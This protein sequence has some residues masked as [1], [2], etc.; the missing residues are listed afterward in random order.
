M[1][2]G[3]EK[4]AMGSKQKFQGGAASPTVTGT[5]RPSPSNALAQ[6]VALLNRGRFADAESALPPHALSASNP[7]V[8]HLRGVIVREQGHHD[9]A[10]A[11]IEAA[12]RLNGRNLAYR[13]DL[14]HAFLMAERFSD[15]IACY[16]RVLRDEP[17]AHPARFGIGMARLGLNDFEAAA[18][19]LQAFVSAVPDHVDGHANLGTALSELGRH[20]E[21]ES[22]LSL[23]LAKRPNHPNLRV[24]Y[25]MALRRRG[26]AAAAA[27][28]L[29][30]AAASAPDLFEAH[31]QL[32]L[33]FVDLVRFDQAM[34]AFRRAAA[35]RPEDRA[36]LNE[37]GKALSRTQHY[38]EAAETFFEL[39]RIDPA[40]PIPQAGLAWTR[41][42]QGRADEARA[43]ME[44]ALAHGMDPAEGWTMLGL[45][46]QA[47]GRFEAAI[48][49]FERAIAAQPTH[50]HAHL[51]LAS[52][53]RADDPATRIAALEQ[54]R[55]QGP[56][57][58]N[59]RATL[60]FAIA[61]EHEK[62]GN[63]D[64]AFAEYRAA[65]ALRLE[66]YPCYFTDYDGR[67]A[68]FVASFSREL[69]ATRA[70][71]GN[72][73][74]R[75]VFVVG[76]MRSGTTLAEQIMASHPDVHGHGELDHLRQIVQ[77]LPDI[78]GGRYPEALSSLDSETAAAL[79]RRYLDPLERSAPDACRSIDKLPHNFEHLGVAALLFPSARIIH[80]V[81]D[82]FD[83][84]LSSYFHDFEAQNSFTYDL[85]LIGR[86]H[87]YVDRLMDHWAAVL[88]NPILRLP[89]EDLVANQE[90][91]SRRL[92]EFLDL[93]WDD[94]CLRFFDNTRSVH[95]YSLWQVRQP[96]Y[97]SAIGRWRP[98]AAH[99]GPLFDALG[100]SHPDAVRAAQLENNA[101]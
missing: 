53:R 93:P 101:L 77:S 83:T 6:A 9:R 98:Y 85:D 28:H 23:A 81:R 68:R 52:L 96:I 56:D 80:C 65:N 57:S 29:E 90:T 64:A 88:P 42:M 86:Y 54:V 87:R 11:L 20:D 22:H 72:P 3:G 17:Q 24:K 69:F 33:A 66:Q 44:A 67:L 8:L 55:A 61:R 10:I 30:Q 48:V 51:C 15:A 50:A 41:H 82:P 13:A 62:A 60:G 12:L 94:R 89:Y 43:M 1:A 19:E 100:L 47:A 75:P 46:E 45:I 97:N 36:V 37:F 32:G 99:L 78:L 74:E 27:H 70:S 2:E 25:G 21:A 63:H 49:A 31:F 39:L 84:C 14:G 18:T 7:A 4:A 16:R 40:S 71:I 5:S 59:Q 26:A 58:C 92:V 73:S 35:L 34:A 95:T 38:D 79:A 91:W 76:M